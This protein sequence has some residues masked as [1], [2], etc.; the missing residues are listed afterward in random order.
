MELVRG[1]KITDYCDQKN[2][3]MRERLDLFT[4]VCQAVQH[5]H[6]KGIIHRDLK[7]SN[8][9]VTVNDGV[10]VPKIIDFGIAK[11]TQMELTEK[12]VFTRFHQFIGTPAYMSPEQAELTSVDIDTRS[13]IYSLG[14]LLYEL[15][16][17]KTPFDA[18]RLLF[19]GFDE[20]RRIIR[21]TEPPKPSTRL[22]QELARAQMGMGSAP[23]P[24]AVAGAPPAT[25]SGSRP[26]IA[27][28]ASAASSADPRGR[29]SATP[30]AGVLPREISADSRR[31]LQNLIPLLRG[32]LDWIVM[33]CLEK[34]RAR[35]YETANGLASDI[36]RHLNNE[37]VVA[38]PPSNLYRFQK[39]VR[40]NKLA[41]AAAGCVAAALVIGL[42]IAL[43]QFIERTRAYN[44]AIAAEK[45]AE[46]EAAKSQQVA[47]FLKDMLAGAGPEVAKGRDATILLEILDKTAERISKELTNQPAVESDLSLTVGRLYR[48]L[49]QYQKAEPPLRR[50]LAISSEL[51]LAGDKAVIMGELAEAL[52]DQGKLAEAEDLQRQAL[53]LSR[54]IRGDDANTAIMLGNLA[55]QLS[56]QGKLSEA[57]LL[58]TESLTI[59]KKLFGDDDPR[60]VS[61]LAALAGVE[62]GQRNYRAAETHLREAAAILEE[63]PGTQDQNLQTIRG[64]LASALEAQEKWQEAEILR[65]EALAV[66]R[67]LLGDDH[68]LVAQMLNNMGRCLFEQG[69]RVEA[70]KMLREALEIQRKSLGNENP[71]LGVALNNLGGALY[72]QGKL[73]DA[74]P[75]L[76]EAVNLYRKKPDWPIKEQC[77]AFDF[78]G[79]ALA[80]QGNLVEAE[81]LQSE[82]L[83]YLRKRAPDDPYLAGATAEL[84]VTLI[85]EHNFAE[86]EPIARECLEFRQKHYPES[87]SAFSA[88]VL[89]GESLLRQKRY[90]ESESLLLSGYEGMEQRKESGFS[91][92]YRYRRQPRLKKALELLVQLYEE[93]GRP[94]RAAEWKQKLAELE[95]A[96]AQPK[97]DAP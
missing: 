2:L 70:E 60:A 45:A 43:W 47:E 93:T 85:A 37:P 7:P 17:G 25:P 64:N 48:A 73:T 74:A 56:G 83:V 89:L 6:Q 87:S 13:D 44:R 9:L 49:G 39:L 62:H 27:P 5:A 78:L 52:F 82:H 34:D 3:S 76:R 61:I 42:A 96:E 94:D 92:D 58:A 97:A 95:K 65:R 40:R 66:Q 72:R 91:N 88:R 71:R 63:K 22:T 29:G 41:F 36:Q 20:M 14:V 12:T 23:A 80:E 18:S 24:G 67:K 30:E 32:D 16:T 1:I 54:R 19:A 35:R 69:K 77:P 26:S 86:A 11:A 8:I 55:G 59:I 4:Q 10:A 84:A 68:P 46:T 75:L 51:N 53:A 21:E 28:R 33:K 90:E 15:L 31:R 38:C 79:K 81:A 57:K 50:A